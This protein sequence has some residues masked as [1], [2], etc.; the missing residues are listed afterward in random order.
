MQR[1]HSTPPPPTTMIF[2]RPALDDAS[3]SYNKAG[4][5]VK[6]AHFIRKS[7]REREQ[8]VV[9]SRHGS[10]MFFHLRWDAELKDGEGDWASVNALAGA[11]LD[12]LYS[13]ASKEQR[14]VLDDTRWDPI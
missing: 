12:D 5:E 11:D 1:R 10:A 13:I 4:E 14:A 8:F 7:G 3:L 9:T 6:Q 2:L